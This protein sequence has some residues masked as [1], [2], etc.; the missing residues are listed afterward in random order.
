MK[1]LAFLTLL[2]ML[3]RFLLPLI[4][5]KIQRQKRKYSTNTNTIWIS[6]PNATLESHSR[7]EAWDIS[8]KSHIYK[9]E[10]CNMR[11]DEPIEWKRCTYLEVD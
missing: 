8:K 10:A 2:I 3:V 6:D 9:G 4:C 11:E 7:K 5:S 1:N